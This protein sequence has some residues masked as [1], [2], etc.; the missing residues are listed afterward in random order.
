MGAKTK[1]KVY[2]VGVDLGATKILV[3]VYDSR[4]NFIGKAKLSTKANRGYRDV[5]RRIARCISDAIDECDISLKQVKAIGIGAPAAVDPDSGKVIF[6]P[7]LKW[8]NKPLRDDLQALIKRPI[9]VDNDCNVCALGVYEQELT[10]KPKSMIGIFLGTG[11]GAGIIL[12][13]KLYHGFNQTAGEIGHM[14]INFD[15]PETTWGSR[16]TFEMYAGRQS[17]YRAIR[18]AIAKG[19]K[20][21]LTE[22]LGPELKDL[23]SGD[24]RKALKRDDALVRRIVHDA[25]VATGIVVGN[26]VNLLNPQVIAL[27]GGIMEALEKEMMPVILETAPRHALPGTIKGIRIFAS[28]LADYAGIAGAA[29]LAKRLSPRQ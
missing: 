2:F 1:K 27:G 7:N 24:L 17:I 23:R 18:E 16:G 3:G 28:K 20:T 14:L 9:Q 12:N 29:V 5:V 11:I 4:L 21:A 6:A 22:M 26:M 19:E 10:P 15:G 8:K 13:G 25:A